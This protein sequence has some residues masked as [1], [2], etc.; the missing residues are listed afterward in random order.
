MSTCNPH[1]TWKYCFQAYVVPLFKKHDCSSKLAAEVRM[2]FSKR[3]LNQADII[4]VNGESNTVMKVF[5]KGIVLKKRLGEDIIIS[6]PWHNQSAIFISKSPQ[7]SIWLKLGN[8]C[9]NENI[10][11]QLLQQLYIYMHL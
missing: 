8:F 10:Q 1:R 5:S 6:I 3:R 11:Q 4:A 2:V 7:S 9:Q